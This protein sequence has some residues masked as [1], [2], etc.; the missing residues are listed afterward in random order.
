MKTY[1]IYDDPKYI[2]QKYGR[3]TVIG[4]T[5]KPNVNAY[6]WKCRCD[7]GNEVVCSPYKAITGHTNS[8]GCYKRDKTIE[9][10]KVKK[11]THGG[12]Y[13]RLYSIWDGMKVR[14]YAPTNKDYPRWGGRG[15][16]VCDEWKNDYAK[17]RE[18]AYANGYDDKLTIDRID[19]NG[20]YEP[21]NCRWIT[22]EAQQRNR[23]NA[24]TIEWDGEP[25]ALAD[26]CE[27]YNV[28]YVTANKAYHKGWDLH[29][30][31]QF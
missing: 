5:R 29:K 30:Y 21:D 24:I 7:C 13:E 16:T 10:N 1:S 25:M 2:G 23:R 31:I 19:P 6:Y 3:L 8:C 27:K 12:R 17:F 22:N 28:K 26:W 20:N 14:C 15:V 18:W 9:S 4:T 11:K